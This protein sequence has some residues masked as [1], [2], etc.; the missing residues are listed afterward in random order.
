MARAAA[1]ARALAVDLRGLGKPLD[2]CVTETLEGLDVDLRGAGCARRKR[3]ARTAEEF[4]LARIS[5]HRAAV[6]E[7]RPPRVAFGAA[8]IALPSGGFLQ[9]TKAGE[10]QLADLVDTAFRDARKVVDLFCGAGSFALRLARRLDVFAADSDTAAVGALERAVAS[11][12]GL[13]RVVA[14][15]RDLFRRPLRSDELRSFDAALFDPPRAGAE[16][17][18]REF[19]ASSLSLIVALSCNAATFARD[20]RILVDGGFRV[21]TVAPLDQ[22]RYSP[23][24]EIVAVFRRP[25]AKARVRRLLG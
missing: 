23:H 11:N 25:R 16:A 5:N 1:A 14:E 10:D 8:L 13:R 24:V 20:A 19:A 6:I 4:D 22:F 18:A 7:R 2:I 15:P 12:R 3:S 17:Q 21:E 9:A